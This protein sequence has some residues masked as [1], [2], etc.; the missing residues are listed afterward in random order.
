M[1]DHIFFTDAT[2]MAAKVRGGELSPVDL[3][4]AHLDR[5]AL[6]NPKIN[7]IATLVEDALDQA[8][9]DNARRHHDEHSQRIA[10][11]ASPAR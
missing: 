3:V 1:E 2:E 10:V 4:G 6:I 9:D 7:A 8:R 5:I 11:S